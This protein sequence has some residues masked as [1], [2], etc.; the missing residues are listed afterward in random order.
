MK[1]KKGLDIYLYRE[2]IKINGQGEKGT[3]GF[4]FSKPDYIAIHMESM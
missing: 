2:K 1:A 3:F 4:G